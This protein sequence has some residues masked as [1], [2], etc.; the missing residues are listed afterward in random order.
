MIWTHLIGVVL[1]SSIYAFSS[2]LLMVLLGLLIGALRVGRSF[3]RIKYDSLFLA[4]AIA[5]L[6]QF[7]LWDLAQIAFALPPFR[8][9]QHFFVVEAYK[10]LVAAVLIVPS[11]ALLGAVFPSLL[12]SPALVGPGATCG[13]GYVSTANS[14]GCLSGA[15]LGVFVMIPK[16][17]SENSLKVIVVA[18]IVVSLLFLWQGRP[19]RTEWVRVA[20][21]SLICLSLAYYWNWDRRLLTAGL[22]LYFG[23][24]IGSTDSSDKAKNISAQI[25]YFHEAAQG[26][27]TTVVESSFTREGR[28][29]KIRTLLTNGKFQGNDVRAVEGEAQIGF[30]LIPTLFVQNVDRA[31]L[32]GLGTGH[33]AL[34]LKQLDYRQIDVAEYSPG[35]VEA[36][37]SS[38]RHL[39]ENVLEDPS[40]RLR[41]EDGRNMLLVDSARL[42]DLI[43]IEITSIWFAGATNVYSREF[44]DLAKKRLRPGGVLQQWVQMHHISPDEISSAIATLRSVFPYVS[45]WNF[46]GQGMMV[47]SLEPQKRA[48]RRGR[49]FS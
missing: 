6:I 36:A 25:I 16:F 27:I 5:V 22:N 44:Y 33:S 15:L 48:M 37:S 42:Y 29:E 8:I 7:R 11:A 19:A 35:I 26:G 10:L 4:C 34:A 12:S 9:F 46:G 21:L 28:Q 31:L 32:I 38:F 30:S 20:T 17:G 24:S 41:L 18:L 39:N 45:F 14:L 40:V 49:R 3:T 47:A 23:T 2:M 43:T 13:V 1:G